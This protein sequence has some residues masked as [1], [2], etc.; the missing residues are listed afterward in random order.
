VP[1]LAGFAPRMRSFSLFSRCHS[2]LLRSALADNL[3]SFWKVYTETEE[4]DRRMLVLMKQ[5]TLVILVS[6]LM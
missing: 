4:R 3:F 1:N 2:A 6:G 5:I